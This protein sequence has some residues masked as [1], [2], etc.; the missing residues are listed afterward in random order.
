[1][2][3]FVI[4]PVVPL[5]A[6]KLPVD[7][8]TSNYPDDGPKL[9]LSVVISTLLLPLLKFRVPNNKAAWPTVGEARQTAMPAV[10]R[11]LE[12]RRDIKL[13]VFNWSLRY[14]FNKNPQKPT[15]HIDRRAYSCEYLLEYI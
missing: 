6:E 15:E 10:K 14:T 9:M 7:G 13:F 2:L 8:G 4:N 11:K 12:G 3:I 5:N 1:L